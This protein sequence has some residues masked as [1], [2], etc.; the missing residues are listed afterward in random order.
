MLSKRTA[1]EIFH[2]I[3]ITE[4]WRITFYIPLNYFNNIG[5]WFNCD[6]ILISL[7]KHSLLVVLK[8]FN[9]FNGYLLLSSS[10]APYI[11]HMCIL[12]RL[13]DNP[14]NVQE[15]FFFSSFFQVKDLPYCWF[16][17]RT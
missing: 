9:S 13:L 16:F 7:S 6:S 11:S 10:I 5:G 17:E 8:F 15:P 3:I 4:I 2:Y 12:F 1:A 14:I